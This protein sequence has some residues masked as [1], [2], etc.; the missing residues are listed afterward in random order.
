MAVLL[1]LPPYPDA[2][3]GKNERYEQYKLARMKRRPND[4]RKK[5]NA[6]KIAMLAVKSGELIP[7]PCAKCGTTENVQRHHAN[8]DKPKE[9]V[10]LC[11]KHHMEL[12]GIF[13]GRPEKKENSE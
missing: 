6:R 4:I 1:D 12:H 10:W 5:R 9:I 3:S 7:Q 11:K 2:E 8:Y 13:E